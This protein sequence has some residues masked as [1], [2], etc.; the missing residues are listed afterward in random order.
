MPPRQSRKRKAT[1][2]AAPPDE[3]PGP[4]ACKVLPTLGQATF[5]DRASTAKKCCLSDSMYKWEDEFGSG[6]LKVAD[7]VATEKY[8]GWRALWIGDALFSRQGKTHDFQAASEFF[9]HR[10]PSGVIL[11]GELR[12]R[13]VKGDRGLVAGLCSK[14]YEDVT[15]T[16]L[17]YF[18]FDAPSLAGNYL[19]RMAEAKRLCPPSENVFFCDAK[20]CVDRA[21]L[22][23]Y[24][25][26]IIEAGGEGVVMHRVQGPYQWQ[27]SSKRTS[28]TIKYKPYYEQEVKCVGTAA[29][30]YAYA[31]FPNSKGKFS[32][33]TLA[34]PQRHGAIFR[35]KFLGLKKSG[36]PEHPAFLDRSPDRQDWAWLCSQFPPPKDVHLGTL[37]RKLSAVTE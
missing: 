6:A 10:L 4:K 19:E 34:H 8:D 9:S 36:V 13:G 17:G 15:A 18:I 14:L 16:E 27:A 37:Q 29:T 24:R 23:A 3:L 31:V 35:I 30:G 22:R 5:G 33:N 7:Y 20:L 25:D 26:S 11:D 2:A 28:A 12:H 1:A 21:S 32:V